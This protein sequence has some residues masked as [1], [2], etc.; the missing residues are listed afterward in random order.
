M[1]T[2]HG[3]LFPSRAGLGWEQSISHFLG[4]QR[5]YELAKVRIRSVEAHILPFPTQAKDTGARCM[6]PSG[7]KKESFLS[8]AVGVA[9]LQPPLTMTSNEHRCTLATTARLTSDISYKLEQHS[10]R[11]VDQCHLL[12]GVRRQERIEEHKA[13]PRLGNNTRIRTQVSQTRATICTWPPG[14]G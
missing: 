11:Q 14:S 6:R 12:M 4:R 3:N 9:T 13:C 7:P 10:E 8:K 1:T 2:P 5:S